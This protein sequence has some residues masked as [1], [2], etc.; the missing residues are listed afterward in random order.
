MYTLVACFKEDVKNFLG[1]KDPCGALW[2]FLVS[3]LLSE[4]ITALVGEPLEVG[5]PLLRLIWS[6]GNKRTD[7]RTSFVSHAY[8]TSLP[9]RWMSYKLRSCYVVPLS[10][11]QNTTYVFGLPCLIFGMK[12]KPFISGKPR[13]KGLIRVKWFEISARRVG[14]RGNEGGWLG[15]FA[16]AIY[17]T[18]CTW[19]EPNLLNYSSPQAFSISPRITWL[20]R[21]I[22]RVFLAFTGEIMYSCF[23]NTTNKVNIDP[24]QLQS[25]AIK[26]YV[27]LNILLY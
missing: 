20:L 18:S 26:F 23:T 12:R 21:F 3:F 11:S 2:A 10:T 6:E 1:S 17:P 24:S 13:V 22:S 5:H 27:Q 14:L 7:N 25:S 4:A 8:H 16:Q 19:A 15:G 9:H